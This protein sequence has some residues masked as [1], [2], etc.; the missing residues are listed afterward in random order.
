MKAK[1]ILKQKQCK[2]KY[3]YETNSDFETKTI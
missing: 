1:T 3:N 2:T